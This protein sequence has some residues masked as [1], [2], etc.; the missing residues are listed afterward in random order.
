MPGALSLVETL[1]KK[2]IPMAVGTSS[3]RNVFEMKSKKLQDFYTNFHSIVCGDEVSQGKPS[4]DIF[5]ECLS[6]FPTPPHPAN[7]LVFE[8]AWNGVLAARAAGMQVVWI[9]DERT[10]VSIA[11]TNEEVKV[12][13]SLTEFNPK[14]FGL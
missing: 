5:L 8:D 12:L 1:K 6:R 13:A 9:P 14:L 7:C 3:A 11:A 4:P 10:D 2:G